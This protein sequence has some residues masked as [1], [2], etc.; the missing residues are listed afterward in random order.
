MA[1]LPLPRD[2][3]FSS[4]SAIAE[5]KEDNSLRNSGRAF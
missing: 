1:T 3:A 4:E 5:E 2:P